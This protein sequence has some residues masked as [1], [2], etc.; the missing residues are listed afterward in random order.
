MI[1]TF[2]SKSTEKYLDQFVFA[3]GGGAVIDEAKAW[4]KEHGKYVIAIPTTGAGATE[5]THAVKWTDTEKINIP[6]DK[7]L[8]I[9]PPFEVEL[10]PKARKDTCYDMIG[11]LVDY[12]NV[13]SDNEIV[14]AGVYM[15]KLIEK[16]PTNLT[17]PASYPYTIR[18]EMTHGEAVGHVLPECIKK[19]HD[20]REKGN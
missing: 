1:K 19:L 4:A 16:H 14:E 17:H 10:T 3:I 2:T 13:A 12:L 18:K 8:T 15:G 9:L 20:L 7:C 6:T 5:T 11:H